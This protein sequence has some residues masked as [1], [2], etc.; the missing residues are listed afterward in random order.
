MK[1]PPTD[2]HVDSEAREA[3]RVLLRGDAGLHDAA[4]RRDVGVADGL[5][6]GRKVR[7]GAEREAS[8]FATFA[9]TQYERHQRSSPR[10]QN[11]ISHPQ[12]R[13][14]HPR[15]DLVDGVHVAELIKR[16]EELV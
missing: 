10:P 15:T 2:L 11:P 1:L 12:W 6:A 3:R 14:L 4:S 7:G 9:T 16:R 8:L 13:K 5:C